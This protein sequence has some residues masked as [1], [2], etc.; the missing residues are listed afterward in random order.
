MSQKNKAYSPATRWPKDV[1]PED[2]S[3]GW[4][5]PDE[6]PYP[7]EADWREDKIIQHLLHHAI[8]IPSKPPPGTFHVFSADGTKMTIPTRYRIP[9]LWLE[10]YKWKSLFLVLNSNSTSEWKKY[11]LRVLYLSMI[12]A[13]FIEQARHA[14]PIGSKNISRTWR[15]PMFN[16]VL[17]RVRDGHLDQ[18]PISI[19]EYWDEFGGLAYKEDD[20]L[21]GDLR[22]V[23]GKGS[24]V[25]TPWTLDDQQLAEG[26]SISQSTEGLV[27]QDGKWVWPS[28]P[29]CPVYWARHSTAAPSSVVISKL[30][31][32]SDD[33]GDSSAM[34]RHA[35][36]PNL[37]HSNRSD[38]FS[39][40]LSHHESPAKHIETGKETRNDFEKQV[41]PAR[42]GIPS[43]LDSPIPRSIPSP[44]PTNQ[45]QLPELQTDGNSR[46]PPEISWEQET[47]SVSVAVLGAQTRHPD[48]GDDFSRYNDEMDTAVPSTSTVDQAMTSP[49]TLPTIPAAASVEQSS[50][51]HSSVAIPPVSAPL[52][53]KNERTWALKDPS[54]QTMAGPSSVSQSSNVSNV[55]EP[56]VL[57]VRAP[58]SFHH[59]S[60]G[61]VQHDTPVGFRPEATNNFQPAVTNQQRYLVFNSL[62]AV[63]SIPVT[64]YARIPD[65]FRRNHL[66]FGPNQSMHTS[67]DHPSSI[68]AISPIA[69]FNGHCS[70]SPNSPLTPNH[71]LNT[72]PAN[73]AFNPSSSLATKQHEEA[74]R[75]L[76]KATQEHQEATVTLQNARDKLRGDEL[77]LRHAQN[78]TLEERKITIAQ[79]SVIRQLQQ[80]TKARDQE[81]TE[82]EESLKRR[83]ALLKEKLELLKKQENSSNERLQRAQE[84]ETRATEHEER[85]NEEERVAK[86]RIKVQEAL[87]LG[88]VKLVREDVKQQE[89][90]LL[91][92]EERVRKW[93]TRV[94]EREDAVRIQDG[95]N[96]D[97]EA[98]NRKHA[99]R[100]DEREREQHELLRRKEARLGE[101]A[102]EVEESARKQEERLE[103][104]TREQEEDARQQRLIL[105]QIRADYETV[106]TEN[107]V[108]KRRLSVTS[109]H[110]SSFPP[111]SRIRLE[112]TAQGP[113]PSTLGPD[114]DASSM[115]M[116]P[117]DTGSHRHQPI[118]TH[119]PFSHSH[120]MPQSSA[121]SGVKTHQTSHSI[122]HNLSVVGAS[123]NI[124]S[125]EV[126][127]R[128]QSQTTGWARRKFQKFTE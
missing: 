28:N 45:P 35:N 97:W 67:L 64:P 57:Q 19:K 23:F 113:S 111:A 3:Y 14:A 118:P 60:N 52:A 11:K 56:V 58:N 95:R 12:T 18:E 108:L 32:R 105:S 61:G 87:S 22:K 63:S 121:S 107:D 54:S 90:L 55:F 125:R 1:L 109:F 92:R 40:R 126:P 78:L 29:D 44:R 74:I 123:T 86:E 66:S 83:E 21:Y 20:I 84:T 81:L 16:R 88:R 128:S 106:Q 93:E 72:F 59:D 69:R 100:L 10:L 73:P 89:R 65:H 31:A 82:R 102:R 41:Q 25:T 98:L 96:S 4:K 80:E 27:Q 15:C 49:V 119:D 5:H 24:K 75:A 6:L 122:A 71:P 9:L 53:Q 124:T 77:Q 43:R 30:P 85:A 104:R 114:D 36:E 127:S 112:E 120:S 39:G 34:P 38:L 26:L 8:T 48:D 116:S 115:E 76:Q 46:S 103:A 13:S 101:R 68:S 110:N 2:E 99:S 117:P 79:R 62:P 70:S 91:E 33:I 42:V 51:N 47:V 94:G 50:L 7:E 37:R 17:R